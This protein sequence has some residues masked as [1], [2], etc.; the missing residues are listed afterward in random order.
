[1]R[2]V[3]PAVFMTGK[4][5]PIDSE[6]YKWLLFIGCSEEV[7]DKYAYRYTGKTGA[8]RGVELYGRRCYMSFEPGLNPNVQKIRTDIKAYIDNI[9]SSKHGSVLEHVTFTFNIENVSR[10]FTGEMNRHRAGVAI[11]EGSMRFIRYND[12][13]IVDVPSIRA[14]HE[15]DPMLREKSYTRRAIESL[16]TN[17]EATYRGMVG[18][19]SAILEGKE[20]AGKKHITSMLRRIIP[21]GVATGGVWTFNIRAL[22]H[23]ITMRVSPAAE[24]EIL[25]VA[26]MILERMMVEEPVLFGDFAKGEDGFWRPKYEKV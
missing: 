20:F 6:I 21:M 1:M 17:I 25:L 7:A 12:I 3:K 8:E 11:S 14:D 18:T 23:M 9:M 5:V 10:V 2:F 19:W 15:S 4:W 24:E 13:P 16:C 26:S 22:R